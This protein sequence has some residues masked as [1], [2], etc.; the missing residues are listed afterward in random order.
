MNPREQF[1]EAKLPSGGPWLKAAR[2]KALEGFSFPA[3][4]LESWRY[5][6]TRG[7]SKLSCHPTVGLETEIPAE[8][9]E[10]LAYPLEARLTF[11]NG[12]LKSA[13]SLP[14]GV[15]A[16]PLAEALKTP[17][18]KAFVE[19]RTDGHFCGVNTAFLGDGIFLKV[20]PGVTVELPIYLLLLAGAG[21]QPGVSHP[22]ILVSAGE[23]SRVKIVEQDAGTCASPYFTN[24]VTQVRVEQGAWVEYIK[25]QDEGRSAYHLTHTTVDMAKD[26]HYRLDTVMIGGLL[27][28]SEIEINLGQGAEC[29]LNG[30][31]M[32]RGEQHLDNRIIINHNSPDTTSRQY[33]KG[34]L[35]NKATGVF[36]GIVVV[37]PGA[38]KSDASQT[39]KNLLLSDD[40]TINTKPQLEI[41]ADDVKCAH[42]ATTGKLDAEALFYLRTRG[43]GEEDARSLLTYAFASDVVSRFTVEAV[44]KRVTDKIEGWLMNRE[45]A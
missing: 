2:E 15:T 43:I 35:D 9:V 28:R 17:E 14:E 5:T 24:L 13:A 33:F 6:D 37:K 31:F 16:V 45:E 29:E 8:A 20:E 4:K 34:I 41:Y 21:S 12:R 23:N 36:D 18:V 26:S 7:I 25:V 22:T 40:A 11:Y 39:N 10:R 44:K 30:L 42:G 3:R 38:Q 32:G 27:A 1:Q 19:G